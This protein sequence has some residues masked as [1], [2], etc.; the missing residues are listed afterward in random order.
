MDVGGW[1]CVDS[2]F[3]SAVERVLSVPENLLSYIMYHATYSTC[4]SSLTHTASVLLQYMLDLHHLSTLVC[5]CL[6]LSP[7][8]PPSLPHSPH[9]CSISRSF[10]PFFADLAH[11]GHEESYNPPPEYLP[12][13]EEV[14]SAVQS[15]PSAPCRTL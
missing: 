14:S 7:T 4:E 11:S 2:V 1:V 5:L 8:L 9:P 13:E 15:L 6:S 10:H 12:T 3:R